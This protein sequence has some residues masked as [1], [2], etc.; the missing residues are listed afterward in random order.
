MS[1]LPIKGRDDRASDVRETLNCSYY[2]VTRQ[3]CRSLIE[4]YASGVV[5]L[6]ALCTLEQETKYGFTVSSRHEAGCNGFEN[7]AKAPA[8]HTGLGGTDIGF[9]QSLVFPCNVELVARPDV[10]IPSLIRLEVFDDGKGI[11]GQA[12]YKFYSLVVPSRK[13]IETVGHGK[14]NV[15][16]V[17]DRLC[18]TSSDSNGENV[19]AASNGVDVGSGFDAEFER[20]LRFLSR[21]YAIVS[22]WCWII[23][24]SYFN[25]VAEPSVESVFEGWEFGYGPIDTSECGKEIIFHEEAIRDVVEKRDGGTRGARF[26]SLPHVQAG[27]AQAD[28]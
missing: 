21:Y 12:L 8:C 23:S 20:Q 10:V 11:L 25:V 7:L 3:G 24:D 19:Q 2:G 13:V 15:G 27:T 9:K 14:V 18:V 5:H 4:A 26:E 6:G 22:R 16:R 1:G 17:R 28:G